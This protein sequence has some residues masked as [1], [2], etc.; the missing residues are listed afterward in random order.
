MPKQSASKLDEHP[1]IKA[2]RVLQP[3]RV[4]FQGIEILEKNRKSAI[5][6]IPGIGQGGSA[7]IAK[8]CSYESARVERTIY[9]A[10]PPIC[11]CLASITTASCGLTSSGAGSSSKM[12]ARKDIAADRGTSRACRAVARYHARIGSAPCRCIPAARPRTQPLLGTPP[13]GACC[14]GEGRRRAHAELDD[15]SLLESIVS[16]CDLLKGHWRKVEQWC[17]PVP[18]TLV[19]GDF[20]RKNVVVRPRAPHFRP[21]F[22]AEDALWQ[23]QLA[24]LQAIVS[25]YQALGGG[26]EPKVGRPVDAL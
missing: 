21:L 22:Q 5:Y 11:R 25:L 13:I 7:V 15:R 17:E 2:W 14:A 24:R 12:S 23:A 4:E 16:H 20:V 18:R 3:G 10:I 19:H 9:E 1:A 26:W 6:R 8:Q